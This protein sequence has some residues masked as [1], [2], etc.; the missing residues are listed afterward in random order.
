MAT[1]KTPTFDYDAVRTEMGTILSQ[2][3]QTREA[4][5]DVLRYSRGLDNLADQIQK[6]EF[7]VFEQV[8][9][10]MRD[11]LTELL[12]NVAEVLNPL[13]TVSWQESDVERG[14]LQLKFGILE[15]AYSD[16]EA[17]NQLIIDLTKATAKAVNPGGP[18]KE[19]T[20]GEAIEG[21]PAFVQVT[22]AG[23][24]LSL[25]KANG[26]SSVGNV[27]SAIVTWMQN[28]QGVVVSEEEKAAIGEAVRQSIEDN[29]PLVQLGTMT[30][31][32]A[33]KD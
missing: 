19:R 22:V 18:R 10:A 27:K 15:G 30:I 26:R 32:H 5:K 8:D 29:T 25:Q 17:V 7:H 28:K 33:T 23:V 4:N 13:S 3:Q 1:T 16:I 2:A 12:R 20:A 24:K 21:R 11:D 9:S 6:D 14:I 31:E